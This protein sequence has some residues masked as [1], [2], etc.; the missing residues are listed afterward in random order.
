MST[1]FDAEAVRFESRMLNIVVRCGDDHES[2][3]KEMDEIMCDTLEKFGCHKGV[4]IFRKSE[5]WYA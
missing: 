2:C 3:H 5:K 1:I 4:E